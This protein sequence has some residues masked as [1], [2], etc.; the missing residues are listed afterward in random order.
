MVIFQGIEYPTKEIVVTINGDEYQ[1]IVAPIEL[2]EALMND[3]G[4]Q[5]DEAKAIDE[6]IYYYCDSEEWCM[7]DENLGKYLSE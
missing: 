6:S 5:N 1:Y 7:S 4:Y 3:D 2:E